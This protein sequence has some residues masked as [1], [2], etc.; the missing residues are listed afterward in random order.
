MSDK[1]T[2]CGITFTDSSDG[3]FKVL[4]V[5]RGSNG[6]KAGLRPGDIIRTMNLV[7]P[8]SLSALVQ[9]ID[10]LQPGQHFDLAGHRDSNYLKVR[11][12]KD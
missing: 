9:L 12:K 10:Y 1:E 5:E 4:G 3:G 7:F 11:V 6:A 2:I 8:A